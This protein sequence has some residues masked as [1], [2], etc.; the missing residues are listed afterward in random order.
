MRIEELLQF[1]VSCCFDY[2]S[3]L[4]VY[5]HNRP[6]GQCLGTRALQRLGSQEVGIAPDNTRTPRLRMGAACCSS[7]SWKGAC[8]GIPLEL[9]MYNTFMTF[10]KIASG[11][12]GST[13]AIE[14]FLMS[15][16]TTMSGELWH[17][18]RTRAL[19]SSGMPLQVLETAK[20]SVTI[21]ALKL[22]LVGRRG[23]THGSLYLSQRHNLKER[24]LLVAIQ[25]V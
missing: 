14:R 9:S 13:W 22:F 7:F 8:K 23:G 4:S 3:K 18:K 1:P 19:T 15:I 2:P 12:F 5:S 10:Q 11:E 25:N 20:V 17:S 21:V 6:S 16:F 24:Q